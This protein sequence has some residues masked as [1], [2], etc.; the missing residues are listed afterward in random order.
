[1]VELRTEFMGGLDD[2]TYTMRAENPTYDGTKD[3]VSIMARVADG[4]MEGSGLPDYYNLSPKEGAKS[5]IAF[6][7][8]K[9]AALMLATGLEQPKQ[10][11]NN[12]ERDKYYV[13]L[14]VSLK[15]GGVTSLVGKLE[16]AMFKGTIKTN[17]QGYS[18]I[19]KYES[20]EK[21]GAPTKSW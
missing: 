17:K 18:N 5:P 9:L 6:G 3:T 19:V 11:A 14:A 8:M 12:E 20:V 15:N 2:G 16:G 21:T 7:V 4:E 1:M 10:F 13:D